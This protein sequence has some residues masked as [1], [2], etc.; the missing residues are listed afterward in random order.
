M[1]RSGNARTSD[2]VPCEI[3]DREGRAVYAVQRLAVSTS[4]MIGGISHA[5]DDGFLHMLA[6]QYDSVASDVC[7]ERNDNDIRVFYALL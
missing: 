3:M 5:F 7:K 2:A 1:I 6:T 4:R